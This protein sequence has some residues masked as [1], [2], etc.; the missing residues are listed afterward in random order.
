[1]HRLSAWVNKLTK[2]PQLL[3][4]G[5]ALPVGRGLRRRL[6]ALGGAP[7]GKEG[8]ELPV[9]PAGEVPHRGVCTLPTKLRK[10]C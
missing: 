7:Q 10:A 9:Q 8:R 1:M 4:P 5:Q 3:E 6:H 2:P